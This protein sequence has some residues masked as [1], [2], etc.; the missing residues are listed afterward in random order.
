MVNERTC[1]I[2]NSKYAYCNRCP[3][4]KNVPSW[5]NLYDTEECKKVFEIC[6]AYV[7]KLITKGDAMIKLKSFKIPSHLGDKYQKIVDEIMHVEKPSIKKRN[8]R[9]K[10]VVNDD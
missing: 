9:K 10:E 3:G 5:K 1:I 8:T 7:N 6:S 2:C 4:G